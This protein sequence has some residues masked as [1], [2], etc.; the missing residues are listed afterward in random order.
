MVIGNWHAHEFGMECITCQGKSNFNHG[1]GSNDSAS[2]RLAHT[3]N[4]SLT[5]LFL[6]V[7]PCSRAISL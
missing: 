5:T 7:T 4:I 1:T 3:Y 2:G 6:S